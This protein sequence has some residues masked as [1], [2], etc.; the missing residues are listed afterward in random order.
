MAYV[1]SFMHYTYTMNCRGIEGVFTGMYTQLILTLDEYGYSPEF[2][3]MLDVLAGTIIRQ[4]QC[5]N[6]ITEGN[7]ITLVLSNFIPLL[8][9]IKCNLSF[10][11]YDGKSIPST[12]SCGYTRLL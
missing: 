10:S 4:P 12:F 7:V 9:G 6:Y 2:V 5:R 11:L 1:R 8:K 3:L